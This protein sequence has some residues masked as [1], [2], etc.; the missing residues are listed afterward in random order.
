MKEVLLVARSR[1]SGDSY[2]RLYCAS[3]YKATGTIVKELRCFHPP[4]LPYFGVEWLG[5]ASMFLV[6]VP[7]S[8][9]ER[10]WRGIEAKQRA[11]RTKIVYERRSTTF[12]RPSSRPKL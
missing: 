9:V 6:Y 8:Q 1:G 11:C 12:S 4:S 3:I 10:N 7:T 2:S 5:E